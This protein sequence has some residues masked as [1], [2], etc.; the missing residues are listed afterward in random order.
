MPF[1]PFLEKFSSFTTGRL[2]LQPIEAYDQTL[3]KGTL[4]TY[5]WFVRNNDELQILGLYM[6]YIP[7][8]LLATKFK[9][10]G[11]DEVW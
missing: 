5:W 1:H 10:T 11:H 8:S 2:L 7:Y 9:S 4:K 3:H 6:D